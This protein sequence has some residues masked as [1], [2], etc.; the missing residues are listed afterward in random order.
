MN[1]ELKSAIEQSA[2]RL[3]IEPEV[4]QAVIAVESAGRLFANVNGKP[5][6]LIRFEG[7][8]FDRRLVGISQ[9]RARLRGLSSPRAGVIK[10]P[11][12]QTARWK[13]LEKAKLINHNAALESTSWGIGQ[14]MGAHWKWLGFE[15]IDAFVIE[16]RAG[17]AGQLR[18][19]ELYIEKAGL[20]SALKSKDWSVF[21]K[22]YNGPAYGQNGY[23]LKLAQAYRVAKKEAANQSVGPVS[24]PTPKYVHLGNTGEAVLDLQNLLSVLGYNNP[25]NGLFDENTATAVKAFQKQSGLES[26]GIV[27][28]QTLN[29]LA[30]ASASHQPFATFWRWL[31]SLL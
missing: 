2:L 1:E 3:G 23:H 24:T 15:S 27:G 31:R 12:S 28:P 11:A 22:G 6:P 30:Q 10:N 16:A 8:Y 17:I 5:E 7:H 21:A 26:D 4:F 14:V 13:L 9:A 19:M 20:V 18:L 25:R 29:A